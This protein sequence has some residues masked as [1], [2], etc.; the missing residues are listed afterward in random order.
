MIP[1]SLGGKPGLQA[2]V[3]PCVSVFMGLTRIIPRYT[4]PRLKRVRSSS[5]SIDLRRED[6]GVGTGSAR[7]VN[8][9][10]TVH[11]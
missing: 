4:R 7:P 2:L 1:W 8:L 3:G 11:F 10:G 6:F 5:A 9:H